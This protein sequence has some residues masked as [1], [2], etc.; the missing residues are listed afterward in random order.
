MPRADTLSVI[1]AA[2]LAILQLPVAGPRRWGVFDADLNRR[3]GRQRADEVVRQHQTEVG[4]AG[5]WPRNCRRDRVGAVI[6][7]DEVLRRRR[8][9]QY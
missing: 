1:G 2:S 5:Q 8:R 3:A 7:D 4:A 9:P 6:G